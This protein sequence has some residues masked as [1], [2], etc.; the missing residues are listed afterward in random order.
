MAWV[1]CDFLMV[2][3]WALADPGTA[4]AEI[5]KLVLGPDAEVRCHTISSVATTLGSSHPNEVLVLME[6]G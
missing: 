4:L 2:V 5:E 1:P 6:G 3:M